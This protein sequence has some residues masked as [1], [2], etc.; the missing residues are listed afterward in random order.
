MQISKFLPKFAMLGAAHAV[1]ISPCL[2]PY[3]DTFWADD[4][5]RYD[6][7]NLLAT[8]QGPALDR[9]DSRADCFQNQVK[10]A[11]KQAPQT[12]SVTVCYHGSIPAS[13]ES[14]HW[15]DYSSLYYGYI[16]YNK[17]KGVG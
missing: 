16:G 3:C 5:A 14:D 9:R 12:A 15:M 1:S 2:L 4:A 8:A 17:C 10:A 13:D 11:A 6:T 7:Y